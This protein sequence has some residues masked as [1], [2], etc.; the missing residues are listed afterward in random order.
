MAEHENNLN[1][2]ENFMRELCRSLQD[3]EFREVVRELIDDAERRDARNVPLNESVITNRDLPEDGIRLPSSPATLM[4]EAPLRPVPAMS[5]LRGK[6]RESPS[7]KKSRHSSVTPL[8]T[9]SNDGAQRVDNQT[10]HGRVDDATSVFHLY[11]DRELRT[12]AA[13]AYLYNNNQNHSEATMAGYYPADFDMDYQM[14]LMQSS[15]PL[16]PSSNFATN[17][18]SIEFATMLDYPAA[19]HFVS[20]NFY[21][22][23]VPDRNTLDIDPGA[24][25]VDYD[26]MTA[27]GAV[28]IPA[29]ADE[30]VLPSDNTPRPPYSDEEFYAMGID[31]LI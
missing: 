2:P 27:H 16:P 10:N 3:H 24:Q 29:V 7:I 28:H 1:D 15:A 11:C 23:T 20:R 17:D 5:H 14:P 21:N 4:A 25:D 19:S 6:M 22:H 30:L 26:L 18:A 31:A 13:Q 12:I 9:F 8:P